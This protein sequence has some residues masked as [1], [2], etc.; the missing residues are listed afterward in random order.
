VQPGRFDFCLAQRK[1]Q[2]LSTLYEALVGL[3]CWVVGPSDALRSKNARGVI[4]EHRNRA[5][6]L[7]DH[8]RRAWGGLGRGMGGETTGST[9]LTV[10][11]GLDL[12]RRG[13]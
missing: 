3:D 8:H 5:R 11:A 12:P 4:N 9:D 1:R 7:D 6:D 2:R 10:T 13:S